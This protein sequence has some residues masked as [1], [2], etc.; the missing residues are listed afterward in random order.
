MMLMEVSQYLKQPPS[1]EKSARILYLPE[2]FNRRLS[3][4]RF[5][6]PTVFPAESSTCQLTLGALPPLN[7]SM[8]NVSLLHPL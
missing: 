1:L 4:I 7:L 2:P 6:V 5:D 8:L 3:L